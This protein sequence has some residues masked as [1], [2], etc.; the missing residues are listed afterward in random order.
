M[1]AWREAYRSLRAAPTVSLFAILSLALG[2]G[3]SVAVFSIANALLLRTLAVREPERLALVAASADGRKGYWATHAAWEQI[4]DRRLFES[5]FA[6]SQ[7]KLDLSERG[8]SEPV[9]GLLASEGLFDVLGIRAVQ[10]RGLSAEDEGV[11]ILSHDLWTRRFGGSSD[12]LGRSL[13]LDREPFTIIG[14]APKGFFG[15]EVGSRFD[16]IVPLSTE[17]RFDSPFNQWLRILGRLEPAETLETATLALRAAQ[18]RIRELTMPDYQRARDREAYLREPLSAV[19]AAGGASF[20]R[21]RYRSPIVALIA[22]IG[23]V[24]LIAC[25]NA[26]HLLLARVAGRRREL[27]IRSALGASRFRIVRSLL[28]ESLLLREPRPPGLLLG[29]RM[30][31]LL[32][33]LSTEIYAVFLDVPLDARVVLFTSATGVLT[34]LLFGVA[35]SWRGARAAPMDWYREPRGASR[36]GAS[37]ALLVAQVALSLLI[38]AAAGLF[39]RT[40]DAFATLPLGFEADRVLMVD[41]DSRRGTPESQSRALDAVRSVPGVASAGASVAIPIGFRAM[42]T[43]IDE[44]SLPE[45]DRTAHKNLITPDWFRTLGTRLLSG[46]DFD[47]GD[48]EGEARVAIV[49]ETFA[50][51]LLQVREPLGLLVRESSGSELRI[52]GL[53]EDTVYR[54]VREPVPPTIY[55]P[56]TQETSGAPVFNLVVRPEAATPAFS[57]EAS[58][59]RSKAWSPNSPS[60]SGRWTVR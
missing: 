9:D 55:L 14:V 28:A 43:I 48:R 51:R 17:S 57:P 37:G 35:P 19:S 59:K 3:S 38:I 42:T 45:S 30:G 60:R 41:V 46:R 33:E 53:V 47:S 11:A 2:I 13:S 12:V 8:E 50:R 31:R 49:N 27:A 4:L 24:L 6:W 20:L 1:N 26:A 21:E 10:G 15:P 29:H 7:K 5:A 54:S 36:V 39:L 40:F 22:V 56:L 44:P 58:P 34:A 16:V 52:V 32:V 25:G 23:L 18:P